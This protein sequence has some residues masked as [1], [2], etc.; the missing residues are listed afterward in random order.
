MKNPLV[1]AV[2]LVL[3]CAT[4]PAHAQQG[5]AAAGKAVYTKSCGSCH[6]PDG[7]AKEAIAKMMKVEMRHLGSKEVQA[8]TDAQ[9][10]KDT[11]EGIGKMKP[12]KGLTDKQVADLL[13]YVRTLAIK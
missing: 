9:L 1:P 3:L 12:V 5:D 2:A 10:R 13:A 6:G 8:K 7:A 11:L 4:L